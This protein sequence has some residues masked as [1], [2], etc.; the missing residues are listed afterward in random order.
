M[1]RHM[2]LSAKWIKNFA[3]SS[4]VTVVRAGNYRNLTKILL[5]QKENE[6]EGNT[7]LQ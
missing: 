5:N 7:K 1:A 2:T 4:W 6:F 3:R